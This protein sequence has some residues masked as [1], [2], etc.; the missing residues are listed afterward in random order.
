M[1]AFVLL[2]LRPATPFR[3]HIIAHLDTLL[4]LAFCLYAYRDLY[5]LATF[6]LIPRDLDNAITWARIGLLSLVSIFIPLLRPRTYIPADPANPT[7]KDLITPE[8]TAPLLFFVFYEFMTS[9]VLK[10]WKVPSLPYEDLHPVADY[11]KAD[12]LYGVGPTQL[13]QE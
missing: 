12:Y 7:P 4:L 6:T 1:F 11:D 2:T 9:L 3:R 13:C 10:A 5:P 8:Q